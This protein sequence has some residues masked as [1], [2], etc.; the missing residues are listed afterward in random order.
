MPRVEFDDD[1]PELIRAGRIRFENGS[2]P[3]WLPPGLDHNDVEV[4]LVKKRGRQTCS[5][6]KTAT[7]ST[8]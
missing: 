5:R 6:S 1:A 4:K 7:P 2:M 8:T 3:F